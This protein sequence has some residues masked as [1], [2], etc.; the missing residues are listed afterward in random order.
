LI[1]RAGDD[2]SLKREANLK[3]AS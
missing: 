2:I 3:P 1:E